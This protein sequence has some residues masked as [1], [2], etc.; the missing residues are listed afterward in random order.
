VQ[1]LWTGTQ[2]G[3]S[4]GVVPNGAGVERIKVNSNEPFTMDFETEAGSVW[5]ITVIY[6]YSDGSREQA[7]NCPRT[8]AGSSAPWPVNPGAH[9]K[10][11]VEVIVIKTLITTGSVSQ[12]NMTLTP[13]NPIGPTPLLPNTPEPFKLPPGYFNFTD[14]LDFPWWKSFIFNYTI[15]TWEHLVALDWNYWN[16]DSFFDIQF[17]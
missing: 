10:V 9:D 12:I 5:K 8:Y 14:P 2:T 17:E 1:L 16:P 6:V 3:D 13:V 11:L 4:I 15:D 7:D